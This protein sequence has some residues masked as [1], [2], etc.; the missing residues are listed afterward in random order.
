MTC[1][2]CGREGL[3]Q[4]PDMVDERAFFLH[5]QVQNP[6]RYYFNHTI[7]TEIIC[8]WCWKWLRGEE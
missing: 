1:N 8:W 4:N 2:I 3:E 6:Q 7:V 5:H